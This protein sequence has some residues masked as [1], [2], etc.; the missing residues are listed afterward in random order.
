MKKIQSLGNLLFFYGR[1]DMPYTYIVQC[2][3]GSFYTGWTT[4]LTARI[5]IHNQGKGGRYTRAR[6]PVRLVYWSI[7][8]DRK[9]AQREEFR[10]K[11]LSRKEK[12]ALVNSFSNQS[13]AFC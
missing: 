9:A 1:K 7:Q 6:C 13:S 11:S 2:A 5:A 3:D 10:I 4:D 12:E 8:P